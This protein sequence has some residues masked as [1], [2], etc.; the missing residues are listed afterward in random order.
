[1]QFC[2]TV[3]PIDALSASE[4]VSVG[5]Y[6]RIRTGANPITGTEARS[7]NH[8]LIDVR[9]KVQFDLCNLEGSINVPFSVVSATSGLLMKENCFENIGEDWVTKMRDLP[10]NKPIFVVCKLGNDSQLAVRKMK[11]LGLD[12]GGRRWIGDVKGGLKAWRNCVD[13]EFPEY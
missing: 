12:C 1:V 6:A 5:N 10:E 13:P 11:E 9:E 4:R 3:S 2:G 7:D 8:V